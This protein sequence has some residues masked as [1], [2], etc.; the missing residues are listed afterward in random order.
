MIPTRICPDPYTHTGGAGTGGRLE[1]TVAEP[2]KHNEGA[3]QAYIAFKVRR[4][5]SP[6]RLT[7]LPS[8]PRPLNHTHT[9]A[10]THA[11][12]VST[13]TDRPEFKLGQTSVI[14]RYSDFEWLGKRLQ[15]A[16]PGAIV[17]PIPSKAL[18]GRFEASF[19]E[20][21]R[22]ALERFLMRVAGHPELGNS[23]DLVTFLQADEA[24]LQHAKDELKRAQ[25]LPPPKKLV[26]MLKSAFTQVIGVGRVALRCE[27][28]GLSHAR[29]AL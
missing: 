2:I 18:V 29:Q 10:Y 19:V 1:I 16:F 14:R 25:M 22:R 13:A 15:S 3:L 9:Y 28:G 4:R 17:P 8:F 20:T 26:S 11:K 27:S 24:A 7:D 6:V 23:A 5:D 21:R 12:K